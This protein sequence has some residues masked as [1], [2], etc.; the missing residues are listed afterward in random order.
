M[1]ILHL[2]KDYFPIEGGIENHVKMLAEA[3]VS[4]GHAVTV[5]VHSLDSHTHIDIINGVR[6]VFAGRLATISSTPLGVEMPRLLARERPDIAHLQFPY[7]WGELAHDFFGRARRTVITYQS[8]IVRQK[9][10][11]VLYAPLLPLI[12]RR[13]QRIIATSPQYIESS[14]VLSRWKE[15]CVVI[16]LAID[17]DPFEHA[18]AHAAQAIRERIG[19]PML[20]FV[21]KLRYYKGLEYL[22]RAMTELPTAHLLIVGTGP[23][24]SEWRALVRDLGVQDRVIFA[25]KIAD[26]DLPAYY[27]ACDVFVLPSSERSEAFGL[28]QLEAMAAGKPIVCTELG[29]GTS[30]VNVH[31]ETGLVVPARDPHAL[32]TALAQL[33]DDAAL[34]R[35]MGLAGQVR[36]RQEFSLAPM[37]DRVMAVYNLI[38]RN[39]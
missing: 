3:Q 8:D 15:K 29:T 10:L 33:L 30:F 21:G 11:R 6:V 31:G 26:A 22:L 13:A 5:L 28:V 4:R 32:A 2:Y 20:L 38:L 19:T 35:R 17:P 16:P 7:P 25:G 14:P 9:F 23:M 18:D 39:N 34:R 24:E 1:K 12:M 27:A 37:V 36:V